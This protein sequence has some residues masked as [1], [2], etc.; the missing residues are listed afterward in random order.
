VK[1]SHYV[2]MLAGIISEHGDMDAEDLIQH[3]MCDPERRSSAIVKLL[4]ATPG[5]SPIQM[6]DEDEENQ[7]NALSIAMN[8]RFGGGRW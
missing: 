7:G 8:N 2:I 1:L 6:Q 3:L 4:N 5:M